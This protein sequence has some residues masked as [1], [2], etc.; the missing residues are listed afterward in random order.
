MTLK[1]RAERGTSQVFP[2][3]EPEELFLTSTNSVL[4]ELSCLPEPM[5]L[6]K[7]I[8]DIRQQAGHRFQPEVIKA[9]M[10]F[11]LKAEAG[12]K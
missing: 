10:K 2:S 9:L 1:N 6:K 3:K 4:P 5:S 8:E 11:A 12:K 7:A